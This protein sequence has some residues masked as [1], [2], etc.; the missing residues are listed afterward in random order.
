MTMINLFRWIHILAGAA[1]LGEVMVVS[2]ILV[3]VLGRLEPDKRGWF[4]ALIFPRIFRLASILAL[5]AILAGAALNLSLSGWDVNLALTRL[6]T[7]RWGWSILMGGALGLGLTLFHFFIEHRLEPHVKAAHEVM[8][9]EA[10]SRMMLRLRIIP[11]AGLAILFLI[12]FLM[13]FAARGF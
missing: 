9:D 2:F 10:F 7:T 4:M 11:R 1:W 5:T 3:P 8:D 13:M 12:F 6:T